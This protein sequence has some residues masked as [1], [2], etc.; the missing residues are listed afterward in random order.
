VTE[1]QSPTIN[2]FNSNVAKVSTITITITI[3]ISEGL[4][5]A[6]HTSGMIRPQHDEQP[7]PSHSFSSRLPAFTRQ[8]PPLVLVM[9]VGVTHDLVT[10]LNG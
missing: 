5:N 8:A 10:Q 6:V 4:S 1:V 2:K 7:Q 3:T 9:S